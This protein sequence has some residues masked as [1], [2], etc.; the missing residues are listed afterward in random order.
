MGA[1]NL[2]RGGSYSGNVSTA[3]VARE[4]LLDILA[5]DYVPR[6][7]LEGAFLLNKPPFDWALP[8]ALKTITTN[9]AKAAG[10]HDRGVIAPGKRADLITVQEVSGWPLVRSVWVSGNRVV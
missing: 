7:L 3:D 6:G 5:S 4:G 10:L 8:K 2:V 9:P 1:P